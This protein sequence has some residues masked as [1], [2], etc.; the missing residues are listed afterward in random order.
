MAEYINKERVIN[1]LV[2][3]KFDYLDAQGSNSD[4]VFDALMRAYARVTQVC[5]EIVKK[6]PVLGKE[7]TINDTGRT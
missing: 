6:S 5:I 7:E 1:D 4:D 2:K 3:L